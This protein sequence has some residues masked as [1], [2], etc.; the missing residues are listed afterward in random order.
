M[1]L[2][3]PKKVTADIS[4]IIYQGTGILLFTTFAM[5]FIDLVTDKQYLKIDCREYCLSCN[6]RDTELE[7]ECGSPRCC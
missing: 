2:K 4:E 7:E 1:K 3:K 6:A 5:F